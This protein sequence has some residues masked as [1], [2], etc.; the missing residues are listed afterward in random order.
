[1]SKQ[2]ASFPYR[3]VVMGVA[4]C[5]KSTIG[6]A[7]AQRIGATYIEADEFHLKSSI[8]K[9]TAG[10]P[11]TDDDRW[12]WLL[13]LRKQLTRATPSAPV[14]VS[15]SSLRKSYRDVLRRAGSGD[16]AGQ[17]RF[18]F[19]DVSETEVLARVTTREGHFMG[20]G[21][22]ASQ[23]AALE[24]PGPEELS[25]LTI[26]AARPVPELLSAALAGLQGTPP[27][28]AKPSLADG[29]PSR[30][31]S[32]EELRHYVNQIVRTNMLDPGCQRV[33]LVPP[34]HTRLYSRAGE[35]TAMMYEQLA[36]AGLEVG[37]LPALGTHVAMSPDD[38]KLLFGESVPHEALIP[39]RWRDGLVT[40][41]EIGAAE[42]FELSEGRFDQPIPV[43]IDEV[44]LQ[45]WNL[46]VS[47]GQVVP[48]EV[49]GLANFT[50][51]LVI[52]LGGAPTVHRSHFLGATAGME[53]I[54]GR[55]ET[56]VRHMVDAA[57]DRFVAPHVNVL[58]VLTVMQDTNT[59]V[60]Q[61]GLFVGHGRSSD[62]GGA[63]YQQAA[64]LAIQCN[65][66]IVTDPFTRVAC[67]LD[68]SE[69]RSTWLGNKAVYR[70]RMA[71]ADDGELIVLAPGVSHFGEDSGIDTLIRRHGYRG[72]P[73]TLDALAVDP[74][75][76]A[77]LS[78][79]AHLIHGSSEGRFR[80]VY[81][82]DPSAGGLT[83]A[84][85][86]EAGYEWRSLPDECARLGV[87][88]SSLTGRHHDVHGVA[89]DFIANPALG[90]W[91]TADRFN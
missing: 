26:N 16:P 42:I 84:E 38:A 3:I 51:N 81:C 80:I 28:L 71:L 36:G 4:G 43:A 20:A 44:L 12:P 72:T 86:E 50:K 15:C 85:V 25:V 30:D 32:A 13:R 53:N 33:L 40:L 9:M 56:P 35:I 58:W 37:V 60:I 34:D 29:G 89:F 22:V 27:D 41:G 70:T 88:G 87:D 62:T 2:P 49:I 64:S 48:H 77:S 31:I 5:G 65:V 1:M 91:A 45:D 66:D 67:W 11:L 14:V 79:A 23:F 10:V 47:V 19:L 83:Q 73:H 78:A 7:L 46:V 24:R 8:D 39:H 63:A 69:F 74:E 90:L 54:M 57:F 17:V 61:R 6:E 52:G 18:V 55:A 76:A 21:M 82:T 59:G 68:P 75:L